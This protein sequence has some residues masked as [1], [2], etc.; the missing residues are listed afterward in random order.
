M[1]IYYAQSRNIKDSKKKIPRSVPL[2]WST[3]KVNAV[4]SQRPILHP[5]FMEF[6]LS[7]FRVILLTNQPIIQMDMGEN[8][9]LAEVSN[10][11]TIGF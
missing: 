5:R 7:F 2:F 6:F 1:L 3:P 11:S 10:L 8:L 4:Y 9:T